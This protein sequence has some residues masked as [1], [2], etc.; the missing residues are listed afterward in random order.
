M[1]AFV[2][3]PE[4]LQSLE[5]GL[6]G[7]RGS[8]FEN[9]PN[10]P[11][12]GLLEDPAEFEE[13]VLRRYCLDDVEPRNAVSV[14]TGCFRG[15]QLEAWASPACAVSSGRALVDFFWLTEPSEAFPQRC[16]STFHRSCGGSAR[17]GATCIRG[18][19]RAGRQFWAP[20]LVDG[21]REQCA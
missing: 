11:V 15:T 12:P 17:L 7:R 19:H 13:A 4:R 1:R 20:G 8:V 6:G 14:E 9:D 10:C 18:S 5:E 3:A 16:F 2:G 21:N